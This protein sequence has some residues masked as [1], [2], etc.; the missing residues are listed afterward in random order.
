LPLLRRRRSIVLTHPDIVTGLLQCRLYQTARGG[1]PTTIE[2]LEVQNDA[3]GRVRHSF[4][5]FILPHQS[6]DV[7]GD[8]RHDLLELVELALSTRENGR[9]HEVE[10]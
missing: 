3:L 1:L 7:L 9:E 2:T 8:A 5:F 10:S 4:L 6:E